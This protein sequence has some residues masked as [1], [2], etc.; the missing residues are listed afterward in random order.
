M[1]IVFHKICAGCD[2]DSTSPAIFNSFLDWLQTQQTNGV[3]IKTVHDVV[4]GAE[5]PPVT[6]PVAN[7]NPGALIQNASLENDQNGDGVPDCWTVGGSGTNTFTSGI[8]NDE[9]TGSFAEKISISSF[10]SG[11][12]RLQTAQDLGQCAPPATPGDSYTAS[13]FLKGSGTYRWVS[14]YRTEQGAWVYWTQ[15]P[16]ISPSSSYVQSSW[17][18]PAVPAGATALSV[19]ISLRST[20]SFTAD[21][22]ALADNSTGDHTAPV[23]AITAPAANASVTGTVPITAT[24][25]DNVGITSVRFFLDGV[26]LGSKTAATPAGSSTYKWNWDTTAVAPGSHVLTTV[27]TDTSGNTTTSAPVT[28]TTGTDSTAPVTTLKCNSKATCAATYNAPVTIT[29][30]ATDNVAV[31][32]TYYT[33]DGS[34]PTATNGNEYTGTFTVSSSALV[35]YRSVDASGNLETVKSQQITIDSGKPTAV[36]TAPADGTNV[37]G[38]VAI[39]ATA[40]DDVA[41]TSVRFLLDGVSLGTK[42]SPTSGSSYKWNWST[43]GVANGSHVLTVTCH[44]LLR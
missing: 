33:T 42:T 38:T 11:D 22:F 13:A 18:T 27:A 30:T 6:G 35:K 8:S 40:T 14:Y 4:G 5:L 1:P 3:T 43:T 9:H 23:V 21:D 19:G 26:S 7:P 34:D 28:V 16:V 20:G 2:V 32:H 12:R 25:T 17:K 39:T 31:A 29:L 24:A 36:I 15:S 10:S 41:V 44:R 37:T